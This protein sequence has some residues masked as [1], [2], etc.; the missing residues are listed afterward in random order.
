MGSVYEWME[1]VRREPEHVRVRYVWGAVGIVMVL[2]FGLWVITLR[3]SFRKAAPTDSQLL[4][5]TASSVSS[6][7][8]EGVPSLE[9]AFG[10]MRQS[11]E[12]GVEDAEER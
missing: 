4:R 8:T 9:D 11:A 3:D 12:G 5:E 2:I 7:T 1:R 6:R 10:A